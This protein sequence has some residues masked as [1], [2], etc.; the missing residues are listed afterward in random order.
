MLYEV[1]TRQQLDESRTRIR[2]SAEELEKGMVSRAITS[3][4]RAQRELEQMR[5]EFRRRTSGEFVDEMRDMRQQAQ[6][7]DEDQKQIA[8]EIKEQLDLRQRTLTDAGVS[9]V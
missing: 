8:E 7:L 1:I 4:T 6:Q 9:V 2:Q 5:D 3:A